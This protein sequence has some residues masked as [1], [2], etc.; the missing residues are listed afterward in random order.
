MSSFS[1][2]FIVIYDEKSS[3]EGFWKGEFSE[4]KSITLMKSSA[5]TDM[6]VLFLPPL[7]KAVWG[8]RALAPYSQLSQY[9]FPICLGMNGRN[10][11]KN[12][13]WL[14]LSAL[15]PPVLFAC[16]AKKVTNSDG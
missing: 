15:S 6:K 11:A 5:V 14:P 12:N 9:S 3:Y 4:M 10:E 1:I 7:Q 13:R 16:K 2:C 8:K